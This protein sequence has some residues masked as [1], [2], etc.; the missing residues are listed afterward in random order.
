MDHGEFKVPAG[1]IFSD[2]F[3]EFR[4]INNISSYEENIY[5]HN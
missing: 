5:V 4:L 3:R 1:H 2:K